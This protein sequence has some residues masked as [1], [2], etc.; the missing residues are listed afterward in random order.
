[1]PK[2]HQQQTPLPVTI[3]NTYYSAL[4]TPPTDSIADEDHI[5]DLET[6]AQ[7]PFSNSAHTA[8]PQYE[9]FLQLLTQSCGL[10]LNLGYGEKKRTKK[11]KQ[12]QMANIS[13]IR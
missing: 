12:M 8:T 7:N 5:P 6:N 13:D 1:M 4:P 2:Q 11:K 9:D 3:V 10:L